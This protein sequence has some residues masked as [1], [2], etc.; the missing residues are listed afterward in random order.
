MNLTAHF[1]RWIDSLGVAEGLAPLALRL[2]LAP[3]MLQSGW[4]KYLGFNGVTSWFEHSLELPFPV[5]MAMLAVG[6]EL[7]GGVLLIIGLGVRLISIPLMIVMLVAAFMVHWDNGWLVL[8]DATSW[9]ANDRVFEA[10][11]KKARAIAILKEHGNYR[12]L[13]SSGSITILNNGIEFAITYF[14]MLLSLFFTGGGRYTSLDYW[15]K[16]RLSGVRP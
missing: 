11:E 14:A 12:W 13:T 3:V 8:S 5:F 1:N 4:N 15:I 9:L 2:Y 7:I 10:V 6:A 16:H